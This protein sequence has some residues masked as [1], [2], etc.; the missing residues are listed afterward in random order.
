MKKKIAVLILSLVLLI[1]TGPAALAAGSPTITINTADSG[2]S[3][4]AYQVFAVNVSGT[5]LTDITWGDRRR[6][7][8]TDCSAGRPVRFDIDGYER[9]ADRRRDPGD[10][11]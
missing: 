7:G 2:R 10:E 5:T 3:Y 1:T 11:A 8:F 6:R 9:R 4:G